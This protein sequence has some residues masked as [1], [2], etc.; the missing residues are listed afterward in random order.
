MSK[1]NIEILNAIRTTASEEYKNRI[2]VAT[3]NNLNTIH[4]SIMEFPNVKNEFI[5]TLTNKIGKTIFLSK[6]Y[7]NPFKFFKKGSLPYGTTIESIFVDIIKGKSFDESFGENEVTSLIGEEKNN[8]VKVEFYEQNFIHKYKMSISDLRLKGAF[9]SANGL[10]DLIQRMV[11]APLNSAQ[12]DEYLM[13]KK[14]ITQLTLKEIGIS[15]F[16]SLDENAQAKKLTKLVK[17]Y[18]E[19]F[20]FMSN[21]YNNQ[22]VMTFTNPE[23]LV[24]LVTPETKANIDVELLA[25]AFN[26]D[27]A[28]IQSRLVTIDSF[29]KKHTDGSEVPDTDTLCIVADENL[30]QYYE[31][32][33]S[34]ETFRNADKLITNTFYH[35]WGIM[36]G[37]GFVNA[38]KIKKL[39]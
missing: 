26:M 31:T 29:T 27:K 15:G 1:T 19:K 32:V 8:N 39:P 12:F 7:E 33:N 3:K 17:T 5:Q 10:S 23:E 28:S 6:F 16:A 9:N 13:T 2:P 30:V 34:T 36:S 4:E 20:K 24:V 21:E 11:Q 18:I 22:G 25:S 37:C 35:R 14:V 38:I